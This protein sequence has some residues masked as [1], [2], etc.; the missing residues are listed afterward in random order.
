MSRC[1]HP[2]QYWSDVSDLIGNRNGQ[3]VMAGD[4]EP[5]YQYKRHR[6]LK[7]LDTVD[8]ADKKVLEVGSGPGGNLL[9]VLKKSPKELTAVDIS[10]NMVKLAT[11]NTNGVV[12]I[13]KINGV[14]FPFDTSVFDIVFSA[15]V[16]QH[17][18]D[19]KMLIS[20]IGEMCRVSHEK[21]IIFERI[22]SSL[23]GDELCM[24]RPVKYYEN[25]FNKN[26]FVLE[27]VAFSNIRISYLVCGTIRKVFNSSKRSEGQP[28]TK[29]S[30]FLQKL[31]LPV[32]KQ[33]DKIFK[34]DTDLAQLV[35]TRK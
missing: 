28:L 22:E 33:L 5:Y 23:Q 9:E 34:S 16:L 12:K 21:V 32:T 1:Y 18:T 24:G 35:F 25:L 6:F 8:F 13:H 31:T 2:E 4:D 30:I 27:T 26:G 15:T 7:M 3:N 10:E 11:K 14:N 20:L 19:E 17:N 29:F